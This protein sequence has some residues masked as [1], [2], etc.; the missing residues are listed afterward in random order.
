MD[1]DKIVKS[2]SAIATLQFQEDVKKEA[3]RLTKEDDIVPVWALEKS[4]QANIPKLIENILSDSLSDF[5]K[6]MMKEL[7][8]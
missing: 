4:I 7:A 2:A 6:E 8:P 3:T 1:I 5:Y